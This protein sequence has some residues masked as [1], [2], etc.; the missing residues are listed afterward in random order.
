M[1]N[2]EQYER[3]WSKAEDYDRLNE[4]ILTSEKVYEAHIK[5]LET[6][7]AELKKFLKIALNDFRELNTNLLTCR[8]C[9]H[10]NV[11]IDDCGYS[12]EDTACECICEWRYADEAKK[13]IGGMENG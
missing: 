11:E 5:R 3:L 6:E 1:T 12:D 2:Q 13:L 7:N 9:K 4:Q 8:Y 10:Y